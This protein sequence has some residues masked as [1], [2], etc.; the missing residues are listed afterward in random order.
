MSA[1]GRWPRAQARTFGVELEFIIVWIWDDEPDPHQDIASDLPP[2]L[3]LPKNLRESGVS[4]LTIDRMVYDRI[5]DVLINHGLPAQRSPT[6]N[7]RHEYYVWK[8]K[9][10][11]SINLEGDIKW[12]G[13]EMTSPAEAALPVAFSAIRYAVDLIRSTYR[14]VVNGSCGFHV[15]VGDG[16]EHMPLE[17]VKRVA[18]LFWAVDPIIALLHPPQRRVNFYSQSIRDRSPLARGNK[19]PD[20]MHESIH[21][22]ER[23]CELYIGRGMRH[24]EHP[25]SWRI[26]YQLEEHV[27]AFEETRKPDC[28]QP[29]FC[30]DTMG[31]PVGILT[32]I[33][34]E[35]APKLHRS[36]TQT[37]IE[38][39][40]KTTNDPK[41]KHPNTPYSPI[42]KRFTQRFVSGKP[43]PDV[44]HRL[45][46]LDEKAK[47]DIGVFAGVSEIF[48]CNSSC[49]ILFLLETEERSNYNLFRY[50]CYN[51]ID[52]GKVAPTI[53]FRE[54]TGT[55]SGQWAEVWAR[56]CVGLTNFAIHAP[57]EDYLSVLHNL[58]RA[59]SREGP[60][61]VVDLLDEIGLYAEAAF[62]EKRLMRYKDEWG[63]EHVSDGG[64]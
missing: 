17:H 25:I 7:S 2:I 43:L 22:E 39:V 40:M 49:M 58:E 18:S 44:K 36:E 55:M 54:A 57:V 35:P 32:S 9:L 62:A 27:E 45:I 11:T 4:K 20:I 29:F 19:I 3:K 52:P 21:Q 51:L 50:K 28:F 15:H 60:Y 46:D 41:V 38:K 63:L 12:S 37:R 16:K 53:E 61:D 13:I 64:K 14:T 31:L 24:G 26:K 59:A 48:A 6:H 56:I 23:N 1:S 30:K 34:T 33:E 5:Y 42:H 47:T 10:D 8:V